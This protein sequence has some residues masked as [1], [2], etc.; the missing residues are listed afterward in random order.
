M[1]GARFVQHVKNWVSGFLQ[2]LFH[3]LFRGRSLAEFKINVSSDAT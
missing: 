1:P 2:T 3:H